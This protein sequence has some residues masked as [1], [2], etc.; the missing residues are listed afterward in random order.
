[1]Y[2][3]II[4]LIGL[5]YMNLNFEQSMLN[6]NEKYNLINNNNFNYEF[7]IKN[8]TQI[9]NSLS[10]YYK[11]KNNLITHETKHIMF[12]FLK[13]II[14]MNLNSTYNIKDIF[15]YI[16]DSID[17]FKLNVSFNSYI[18]NSELFHYG[19]SIY[20]PTEE[21]QSHFLQKNYHNLGFLGLY[22]I[23]ELKEIDIIDEEKSNDIVSFLNRNDYFDSFLLMPI[24]F[25]L[26]FKDEH[27]TDDLIKS[28]FELIK[29]EDNIFDKI[30]N[31]FKTNKSLFSDTSKVNLSEVLTGS[32]SFEILLFLLNKNKTK[33][34]FNLKFL[35]LIFE[36]EYFLNNEKYIQN[37]FDIKLKLNL[38]NE[39]EIYDLLYLIDENDLY[40]YL[41]TN[42]SYLFLEDETHEAIFQQTNNIKTFLYYTL[43]NNKK[44]LKL[45][46][47][48]L[49]SKFNK[50]NYFNILNIMSNNLNNNVIDNVT[51]QIFFNTENSINNFL[52]NCGLNSM[53]SQYLLPIYQD[54][55]DKNI[56]NYINIYKKYD[57]SNDLFKIHFKYLLC[58]VNLSIKDANFRFKNNGF[59]I[60]NNIDF[61]IFENIKNDNNDLFNFFIVE[62]LNL[63]TLSLQKTLNF[64]KVDEKEDF[65]EKYFESLVNTI[66]FKTHFI[67][68]LVLF[69]IPL[70]AILNNN[71]KFNLNYF[72][73]KNIKDFFKINEIDFQTIYPLILNETILKEKSLLKTDYVNNYLVELRKAFF[74]NSKEKNKN[75]ILV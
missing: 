2:N 48:N 70:D 4:T 51:Y 60:F 44:E 32:L 71:L 23:K 16:S 75:K 73:E 53:G 6:L 45:E 20:I 56:D 7:L 21:H 26:V 41:Y 47:Y 37:Y 17:V 68:S 34:N 62:Y 28:I 18:N 69:N 74:T 49:K 59:Y 27:V 54:Y 58:H 24:F 61:N 14:Y 50:I 33:S 15:N 64:I 25:T 46:T 72:N 36:N 31:E 57:K 39:N 40:E 3:K 22:L 63:C 5:L 66:D 30:D 19:A 29:F 52:K 8:K 12:E 42:F 65:L 11:E 10:V 55:L 13:N 35:N 38:L 67:A 43:N 1:M 9:V